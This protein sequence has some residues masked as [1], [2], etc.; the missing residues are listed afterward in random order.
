VTDT[1]IPEIVEL[2][3]QESDWIEWQ[4]WSNIPAEVT[5]R[6]DCGHNTLG[7]EWHMRECPAMGPL[8]R[9]RAKELHDEVWKLRRK[10]AGEP[11]PD[12]EPSIS[13]QDRCCCGP[14]PDTK[15]RF[16]LRGSDACKAGEGS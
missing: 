3:D 8:W 6:C 15:V 16:H 13:I 1:D 9:H 14:Q 7:P 2:S 11:E 10:L 12:E 4:S 5:Y